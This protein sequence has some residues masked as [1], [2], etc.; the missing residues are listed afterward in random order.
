MRSGCAGWLV[1]GLIGSVSAAFGQD[2]DLTILVDGA[3]LEHGGLV[4]IAAAPS[5]DATTEPQTITLTDRYAQITL[6]YPQGAS[7]AF[8]FR[9]VPDAAGRPGL[10]LFATAALTIGTRTEDG[11]DG[12]Q[13]IDTQSIRVFPFAEYGAAEPIER[14]SSAWGET[15]QFDDPPPANVWGARVLEQVFDT[16][17]DRRI[18]RL[19]CTDHASVSVCTP[20]PDDALLMEALWW[21]AIA[22][23]RLERLRFDALSACYD[24]GGLFGRPERC[25]ETVGDG[26]P[27][28]VPGD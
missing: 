21:R 26:W 12:E 3:L 16:F 9:P 28:Y 11:P 2:A 13:Q 8:R 25:D 20:D 4:E 19:I 5:P 23:T 15:E 14:I 17:G 7:Y 10:D 1:A 24:G 22:E 18:V 27:A 6:R